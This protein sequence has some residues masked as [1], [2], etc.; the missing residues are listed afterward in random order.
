MKILI[1]HPSDEIIKTMT[2]SDRKR[3]NITKKRISTIQLKT[4]IRDTIT[5]AFHFSRVPTSY[6]PSTLQEAELRC[7]FSYPN[8]R[9]NSITALK[10]MY[11]IT[12]KK[13]VQ[14]LQYQQFH[15][16]YRDYLTI[17]TLVNIQ[18][19]LKN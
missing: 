4:E 14:I 3:I 9:H 11:M 16:L 10:I 12:S 5:T 15:R 17:G 8:S 2:Y 7:P 6:T 1:Q 18:H 13:R 19:G